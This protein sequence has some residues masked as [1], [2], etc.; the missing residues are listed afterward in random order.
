MGGCGF[1]AIFM[2]QKVLGSLSEVSRGSTKPTNM[3][4]EQEHNF[5]KNCE[6]YYSSIKLLKDTFD[7]MNLNEIEH[8][9]R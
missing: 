4:A 7:L 9:N 5:C 2:T 8:S 1:L 3:I 6:K